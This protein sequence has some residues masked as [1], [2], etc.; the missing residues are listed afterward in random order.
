M[1]VR[2]VR[3]FGHDESPLGAWGATWDDRRI[4]VL[5]LAADVKSGT[6]LDLL[7]GEQPVDVV[8]AIL[9]GWSAYDPSLVEAALRQAHEALE[10]GWDEVAGGDLS[11]G[12]AVLVLSEAGRI[13]AEGTS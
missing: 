3:P 12:R 7:A 10:R 6:D 1:T 13:I 4:G 5:S 11:M 9:A 2:R 8:A